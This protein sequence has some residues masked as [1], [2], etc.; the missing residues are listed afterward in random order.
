M[1]PSGVPLNKYADTFAV[2]EFLHEND[3]LEL[4]TT[5]SGSHLIR[6]KYVKQ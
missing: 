4:T 5:A 3:A 2:L 6:N 1:E